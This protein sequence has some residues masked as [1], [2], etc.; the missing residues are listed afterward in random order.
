MR[1]KKCL[2]LVSVF[3]EASKTFP[4]IFHLGRQQKNL[5]TVYAC[6]ESTDLISET[7]NI[8]LMTHLFKKP[9]ISPLSPCHPFVGTKI[10]VQATE[11][12]APSNITKVEKIDVIASRD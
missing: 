8:P 10:A 4:F 3:K 1:N 11:S 9:F 5:I 7:T 6:K 12:T 2:G